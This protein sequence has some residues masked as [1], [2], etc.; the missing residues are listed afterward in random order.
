M[1]QPPTNVAASIRARLLA[2]AQKRHEDFNLTLQRYAT[3]RF[4]FRLGESRHRTRF[5][6]KGAVLFGVWDGSMYRATR[7]VDFAG[8]GESDSGS[9]VDAIREVCS[10]RDDDGIEFLTDTVRVDPIR[11]E[12]EYGALRLRV[13]ALLDT[14]RI[15]MQVD[16]G[17]GDAIVPDPQEVEYP[18]LLDGKPPRVRAYPREAVITEKVHAMV[19]LGAANSRM[20]DFYDL[21]VL[22]SRFVFD[23]D[24]LARAIVATFERRDTPIPRDQPVALSSAFYA[25]ASRATQW[26][27]Y[28]ERNS[29]SGALADFT[30][31]GEALSEFLMRPLNAAAQG[32][33]LGASWPPNGPWQELE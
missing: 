4:L 2:D 6:L 33:T 25:D 27:R 26:R 11:D 10:V 17:F 13:T 3:E 24:V 1:R 5:V 30:A 28:L 21:F 8:Y 18:T 20:K 22:S 14:A 32:T 7:D 12:G 31:V 15:S 23:G 9:I 16:I 29:L 19:I